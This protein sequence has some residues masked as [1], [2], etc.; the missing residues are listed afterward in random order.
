MHD[1]PRLRFVG[2]TSW[3]GFT[4]RSVQL[5]AQ[6]FVCRLRHGMAGERLAGE[7]LAEGCTA[8]QTSPAA[9]T[10]GPA[11]PPAATVF[12]AAASVFALAS[13]SLLRSGPCGPLPP[14]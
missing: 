7:Q 8:K 3:V 1:R 12:A 10:F 14:Y 2:A 13:L 5:V 4:V 11:Q 6:G 9:E